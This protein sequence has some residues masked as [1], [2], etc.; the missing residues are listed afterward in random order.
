MIAG[1]RRVGLACGSTSVR[2]SKFDPPLS[3]P[4]KENLLFVRVT[5]DSGWQ[6]F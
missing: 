6:F 5:I 1:D 4:T 3:T 2:G